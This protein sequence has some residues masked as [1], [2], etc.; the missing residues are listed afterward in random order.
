MCSNVTRYPQ[1]SSACLSDAEAA[2][3]AAT[4]TDHTTA[5]AADPGTNKLPGS[6]ASMLASATAPSRQQAQPVRSQRAAGCANASAARKGAPLIEELQETMACSPDDCIGTRLTN[7]SPRRPCT[8]VSG[9]EG[10]TWSAER[11]AHALVVRLQS[12]DQVDCSLASIVAGIGSEV[13][14]TVNVPACSALVVTE[15]GY[16]YTHAQAKHSK[17]LRTLTIT[18]PAVSKTA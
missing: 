11:D 17:R 6:L 3:R 15:P 9:G 4:N 16:A 12:T 1:V 18:C 10:L 14:M 7:T 8:R 5:A 13:N 2:E